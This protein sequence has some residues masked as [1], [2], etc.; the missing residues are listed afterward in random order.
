MFW[1]NSLPLASTWPDQPYKTQMTFSCLHYT[2]S[3]WINT[4]RILSSIA[5]SNSESPCIKTFI[6]SNHALYT[7]IVH[8]PFPFLFPQSYFFQ[9]WFFLWVM[10]SIFWVREMLTLCYLFVLISEIPGIRIYFS[11]W[12]LPFEYYYSQSEAKLLTAA[13]LIL[14][15]LNNL[16]C[17]SVLSDLHHISRV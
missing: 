17:G 10:L 15:L 5:L 1:P 2:A 14:Q 11:S 12:W 4:D 3:W 13:A 6:I 16:L 8:F 7:N 9:F